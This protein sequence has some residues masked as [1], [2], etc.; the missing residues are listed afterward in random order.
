MAIVLGRKVERR[1]GLGFH[2]EP[3][4]VA[5][6]GDRELQAEQAFA[7]AA[8]AAKNGDVSRRHQARHQELA[9]RPALA[10]E[11]RGGRGRQRRADAD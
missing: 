4:R 2:A 11:P 5:H 6:D 10:G 1:A 3:W 8:V 9:L 7:D